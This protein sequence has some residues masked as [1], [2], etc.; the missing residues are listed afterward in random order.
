MGFQAIK[1]ERRGPVLRIR[2]NRP[3]K[4]NAQNP[5]LIEEMDAAF[6]AGGA[7]PDVRVIVLSGEGRAFSAGHD[8]A[9]R[10]DLDSDAHYSPATPPGGADAR[11]AAGRAPPPA[12]APGE[13]LT[14]ARRRDAMSSL[15]SRLRSASTSSSSRG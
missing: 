13:T 12:G 1:V 15:C 11:R 7:D 10:L 8:A 9:T 5:T 6:T 14:A 2:M 3:D 4:L